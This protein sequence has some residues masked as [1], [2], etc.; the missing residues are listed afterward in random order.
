MPIGDKEHGRGAEAPSV[1]LDASMSRST[2]ASV[3]CS[4]LRSSALGRRVGTTVRLRLL[5]RLPEARFS[6]PGANHCSYHGA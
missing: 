6:T 3:R 1:A 2:S 4:R 5:R